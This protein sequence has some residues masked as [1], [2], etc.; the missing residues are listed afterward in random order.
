MF[1]I[2]YYINIGSFLVFFIFS[3]LKH[4]KEP[5]DR[6]P[7]GFFIYLFK[8][9]K[10]PCLEGIK[11]S[12]LPIL[13][14]RLTHHISSLFFCKYFPHSSTQSRTDEWTNNENPKLA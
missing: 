10:A 5:T 14:N 12:N 7:V 8:Q 2:I 6:Q 4:K 11:N 1:Y 3:L 9:I 13:G